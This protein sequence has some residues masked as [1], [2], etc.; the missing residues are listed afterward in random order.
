VNLIKR[1]IVIV[2]YPKS[3]NTW[4]RFI[5]AN[6]IRP[7]LNHTFDTVIGLVPALG[8]PEMEMLS[9]DERTGIYKTHSEKDRGFPNVI[10]IIR[11]IGDVLIS[12][13]HHNRKFYDYQKPLTDFIADMGYGNDWHRHIAYWLNKYKRRKRSMVIVRYEDLWKNPLPIILDIVRMFKLHYGEEQVKTAIEKSSFNNM[14]IIEKTQGLGKLYN[15]SDAS[16]LFVREGGIN[17]WLTQ[18]P[19]EIRDEILLRNKTLLDKIYP[20]AT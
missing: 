4:L 19:E 6:L 15:E 1:N 8:S 16:T 5:F 11:H 12:F 14:Q 2:S 9:R 17:K 3:G 20:N 18:V 13:Y 10:Y 7:D